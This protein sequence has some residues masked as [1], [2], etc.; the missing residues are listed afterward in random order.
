M[1]SVCEKVPYHTVS[2]FDRC[3]GLRLSA[4]HIR[5]KGR[6][7]LRQRDHRCTD[8]GVDHHL[9][10]REAITGIELIGHGDY[11]LVDVA[12]RLISSNIKATSSQLTF[13]MRSN[14]QKFTWHQDSLYAQL[15]PDN[16]M[17][18]L[19]ALDDGE[20]RRGRRIGG[21]PGADGGRRSPRISQLDASQVGS[22]PLAG[23]R[24]PGAL[25]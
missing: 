18:T 20:Q 25:P 1:D 8:R 14:T 9:L 16:S 11:L 6:N 15:D 21:D 13:K 19:T 2:G 12:A 23:P 10:Q 4:M 3:K 24:S 5:K 22:Q 7:R 17:T